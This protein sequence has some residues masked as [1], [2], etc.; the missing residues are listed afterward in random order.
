MNA[1]H[2]PIRVEP[3]PAPPLRSAEDSARADHYALLARLFFAAPD[4]GLLAALAETG[5]GYGQGEGP[6][7][8]A[9]AAL[10]ETAAGCDARV[11]QAE[12]DALF[13]GIGRPEVMPYGSFYLAGFLM[14]EPLANLREDLAALGLGRRAG[15]AETEDHFAALA[16]VMRH[17]VLTG[18]DAIGLERQRRFFVR[19]LQPWYARLAETLAAAPQACLYA[20][21]GALALAFLDIER[22]AFAMD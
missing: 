12:F 5:R 9:W 18:P 4:D 14:E 8:N 16:E 15:V 7:A 13:V 17:L 3:P 1:P 19:H 10:G 22:E 11:A 6:L 2:I 20:R 21:V